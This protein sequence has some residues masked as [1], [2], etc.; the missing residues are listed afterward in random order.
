[1]CL[2]STRAKSLRSNDLYG[3]GALTRR[4][5]DYNLQFNYDSGAADHRRALAL[6]TPRSMPVLESSPIH[7]RERA[8]IER[9]SVEASLTADA[10]LRSSARTLARYE[11]PPATTPYPL[12]YAY[13]LLGDVRDKWIVDFG[14]G[15][16]GNSVLLAG[17]GAHVTGV[18][19]SEDL[20]RIARRRMAVNARGDGASF[21]VGSAHDLP[22]PSASVDIVFGIAVLH[23]LDLRL[24]SR[25]VHRVLKPGGRAIFQEPVRN[26]AVVRFVRALIPYRAPDISPY[27]RPLTDRELSG[28]AEPFSAMRSRA[29]TLPH[30]AVGQMLPWTK[31][32][33][34]WLYR[35][36]AALLTRFPALR[37]Y[38]GIRVIEVTK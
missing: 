34:Q 3:S 28:F 38:A 18:D 29:F 4:P 15:S 2:C 10:A 7:T 20:I 11:R 23:H 24:V 30:V 26:S 31:R 14:C 13:H 22:F 6:Q 25:E 33:V 19:I 27:E 36:D 17:R 9:S 37:Y 8:E 5:A 1:M 12:E 35:T 32:R 16:G 21:V